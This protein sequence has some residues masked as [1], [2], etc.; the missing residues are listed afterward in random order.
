MNAAFPSI[1]ATLL[2]LQLVDTTASQ[3][4]SSF[5]ASSATTGR[6]RY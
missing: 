2:L 4:V 6:A 3:S 5:A 1:L